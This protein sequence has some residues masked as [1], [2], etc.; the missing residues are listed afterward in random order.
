MRFL[1][2]QF[3]TFYVPRN[4]ATITRSYSIASEPD[5]A[6]RFRLCV[7]R[8]EGGF[9]SSYLCEQSVGKELNVIGP[10]G[11]FLLRDPGDRTV[12]FVATGTGVGPFVPMLAALLSEHPNQPTWLFFGS[13]SEEDL[14]FRNEFELA[15]R[16]HPNFRYVPSLSRPSAGWTGSTGHIEKPLRQYFPDLSRSD[17]YICGVPQMVGEVQQLAADLACPKERTFVERY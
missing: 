7:K 5:T 3:V 14:I 10:L 15:A 1:P 12:I 13:R 9:V 8:V 2:G 11:R 17:V 16:S 6:D 4:G